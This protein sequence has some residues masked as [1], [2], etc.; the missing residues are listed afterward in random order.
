M[1][2]PQLRA[3]LS[4]ADAGN[5]TRAAERL[6]I[7]QPSLS[8]HILNLEKELGQKL[9][10]RLGRKAVA[11]EAG[12]A[13]IERARRILFEV[14]SATKEL[15]DSPAMERRITVGA[16]QT[17]APYVLPSL[18]Q[19]CRKRF[20]NLRISIQED[21]KVRLLQGILDGELDLALVSLP[22]DDPRVHAEPLLRE[23]LLL[24]VAKDHALAH[25]PQVTAGDLAGETFIMLGS[26]S[27]LTAQVR[28]FCGDHDFEPNIGFRCSQ[29]ATVKGLV[30]L[31]VGISILPR[32][33]ISEDDHAIKYIHLHGA[34]P[35]REIGVLRHLQRYQSRGAEQFLG[36]LRERARELVEGPPV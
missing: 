34:E 30:A 15:S 11:T 31:G 28:S 8:Q 1:D 16:I 4:V 23:P 20:P 12:V 2:I 26:S 27:S 10:H 17:L 36:V 6:G 3:V 24:A 19:R 7:A 35:Y 5:F 18:I 13:F 9:F 29:V 22:A 25:K 32:V 21:F 14:E 33:A